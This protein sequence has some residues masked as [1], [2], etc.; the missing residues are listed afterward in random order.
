MNAGVDRGAGFVHHAS[1]VVIGGR[2]L[3]IAG[4]PGSGKSSLAL[5][6]IDRGAGL[7]G[8]DAVTL[9]LADDRLIASPPP[10]IAGLLEL[11]GVGLLRVPVADPAPVALIL[12]LGGTA[13]PARLPETLPRRDIAGVQVPVL[14]F[15]PGTIAPGPRAEW[16]LQMHGLVFK[17]ASLCRASGQDAQP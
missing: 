11:R 16:A 13:Q 5:A 4:P 2:A 8:D 6:L 10:N 3:L 7:I 14:A 9:T 15:D 17:P 1:A 12:E